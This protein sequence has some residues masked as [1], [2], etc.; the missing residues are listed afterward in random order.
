M[1]QAQVKYGF[2]SNYNGTVFLK[3]EEVQPVDGHVIHSSTSGRE[4]KHGPDEG[5]S[6]RDCTRFIVN[7]ACAE[8]VV[9]PL[10]CL[11]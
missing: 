8:E 5:I 7:H 1:Y 10:R 9:L 2:V 6:V 11:G 4:A 3:Q